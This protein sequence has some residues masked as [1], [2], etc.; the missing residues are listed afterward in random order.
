M[1][2]NLLSD[3][4]A[5]AKALKLS[6]SYLTLRAVGNAHLARRL[7]GGCRPR[8]ATEKKLRR[9]LKAELKARGH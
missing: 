9:F 7:Q 5:A 3:L 4:T 1:S 2:E 8:P 6:P